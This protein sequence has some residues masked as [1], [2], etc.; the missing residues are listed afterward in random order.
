MQPTLDQVLGELIQANK[1]DYI[2]L[3]KG[4][5][6]AFTP[7]KDND[8]RYRLCLSR[9]KTQK[10][11]TREGEIVLRFLGIALAGLG[12]DY[13]MVRVEETVVSSK[14]CIVIEWM[15]LKQGTLPQILE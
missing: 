1:K 7:S 9:P 15:K 5:V 13:E 2:K 6:I 10:P 3:Q 11:S 4:S 12:L 14:P 8:G